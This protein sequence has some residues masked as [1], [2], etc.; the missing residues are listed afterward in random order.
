MH[1]LPY[2]FDKA[3]ARQKLGLAEDDFYFAPLV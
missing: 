1:T 3:A 2:Q